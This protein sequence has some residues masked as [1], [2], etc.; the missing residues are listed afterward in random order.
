MLKNDLGLRLDEDFLYILN[1]LK[2]SLDAFQ[3]EDRVEER[4]LS[5][6][7][8]EKLCGEM[9][10]TITAKRLRNNY[11]TRLVSCFQ[12]G[13]LMD[14]FLNQ[15]PKDNLEPVP[16]LEKPEAN[17]TW[18][19]D[20][21]EEAKELMP[22]TGQQTKDC[23]TYISSKIFDQ[24]RGACA[25]IAVAVADEG[26]I[27]QWIKIGDDLDDYEKHLDLIFSRMTM[28]EKEPD[29]L[30]PE[31]SSK[32]LSIH[33]ELID[34]IDRELAN[35]TEPSLYEPLEEM[36]K[37]YM[38]YVQGSPIAKQ[39]LEFTGV[40]FRKYFLTHLRSELKCDLDDK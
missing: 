39:A 3:N 36:L 1:F 15:P 18:L 32:G 5:N 40:K 7:W 10:T 20:L 11:L 23:Q 35:I 30:K 21:L 27:P 29:K 31:H 4:H 22:T 25:Y 6:L 2:H 37:L 16:L 19:N 38:E 24:N 14:P 28:M 34:A 12:C 26:E 33:E 17:P 13:K 9:H 8:L